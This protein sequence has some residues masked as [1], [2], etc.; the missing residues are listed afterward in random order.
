MKK[1]ITLRSHPAE[2]L[3]DEGIATQPSDLVEFTGFGVD[4]VAEID[5]KRAFE[6]KV[7]ADGE[8]REVHL[9]EGSVGDALE[10]AGVAVNEDDQITPDPAAPL[11]EGT[12]ISIARVE[13]RRVEEIEE[14]PYP[15]VEK[16]TP[17]LPK[18]QVRVTRSG[19]AGEKVCVYEE[20][21]VDGELTQREAVEE[22]I[23]CQPV[24]KTAIVGADVPVSPQPV[25]V[26]EN[27]EP[28]RYERVIT[29]AVATAYSARPGAWTASGFSAVAGTVAVDPDVIPYGTKLYIAT[30]DFSFVYG[31]A[32]AADTGTAIADG[33]IDVDLFFN[34]YLESCLFGKRTVNIYVLETP[35]GEISP[36]APVEIGKYPLDAGPAAE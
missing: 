9:A 4:E 20:T 10:E 6:V 36:T 19:Q 11:E 21:W 25:E 30:P 2:I 7:Q 35:E 14:I 18:G 27:G 15:T 12:E 1:T 23:R 34:T 17:L 31:Y 29:G 33:I 5:I 3:A 13:H 32:V 16:R 24:A 22:N 28:L 26:D 8:T